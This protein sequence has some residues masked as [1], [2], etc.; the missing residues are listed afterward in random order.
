MGRSKQQER[1][2]RNSS[3]VSSSTK[4]DWLICLLARLLAERERRVYALRTRPR[5]ECRSYSI[6]HGGARWF[7][8]VGGGVCARSAS[9]AWRLA[10]SNNNSNSN[11][12]ERELHEIDLVC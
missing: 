3:H 9:V 2:V 11:S 8:F 5:N 12:S 10:H 4:L 1:E 6:D 7:E